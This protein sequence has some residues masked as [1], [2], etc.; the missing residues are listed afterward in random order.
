RHSR[1]LSFDDLEERTALST[2]TVLN[3]LDSGP[4]S[5]RQ[6]LLD[7]NASSGADVIDFNIGS[8]AQTIQPTSPLPAITDAVLIDGTSQPGYAG[9]PLIELDGS[10]AGTGAIGLI[11]SASGCAIQGLVINRFDGNALELDGD[12][13]V[14]TGNYLG[15][16][17]TGALALANGG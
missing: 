9:T 13:N 11:V 7:A 4:G 2:F 17:V 8:G 10:Q 3:N 16:D 6:A 12:S 1:I 15:T 14:V 5:L